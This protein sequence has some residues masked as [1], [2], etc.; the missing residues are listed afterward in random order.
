MA[1]G[2]TSCVF[3]RDSLGSRLVIGQHDAT[4]QLTSPG[5][6]PLIM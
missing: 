4:V 6:A 5:Y 3:A 2:A 1:I